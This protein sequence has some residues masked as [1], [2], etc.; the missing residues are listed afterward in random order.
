YDEILA[1]QICHGLRPEFTEC[2]PTCYV[3]LASQCMDANPSNRPSASYIY[4]ELSR[5]YNIVNHNV[6]K[7]KNEL[8]ILKEFQSADTIIPK[9]STKLP[10]CPKDKFTSRLLN[11]KNLSES[12]SSLSTELLKINGSKKC[13]FSISDD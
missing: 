10:I 6:A 11:F 13:E 3:Q 7:D 2:T 8:T 9:S 4:D 5:W 12:I 1:I